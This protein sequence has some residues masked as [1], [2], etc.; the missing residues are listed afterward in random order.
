V[1]TT[2]PGAGTT[3]VVDDPVLGRLAT[4]D[5]LFITDRYERIETWSTFS[6]R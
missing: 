2:T 6:V 1:P 5:G 3:A 4:A